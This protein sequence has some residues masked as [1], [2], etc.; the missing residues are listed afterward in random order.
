MKSMINMKNTVTVLVWLALNLAVMGPADLQ[1]EPREFRARISGAEQTAEVSDDDLAAE[2]SFGREV[3]AH[4]L[5]RYKLDQDHDLTRYVNLVGRGVALHCNRSE[6]DFRFAVLDTATINAYAAPGGYIFITRGAIGIMADEAELAAVLA[7][8]VAHTSERHIVRE[9]GIK[10]QEQSA[11]AGIAHLLGAMGD[12]TRVAFKQAVDKAMDIL[13]QQG[14]SRLDEFSADQSGTIILAAT[15][16]D[17]SALGRYLGRLKDNN[18]EALA[19]LDKTHP[20]LDERI[21][22]LD[23]VL[24]EAG[25][26]RI[27]APT[28]QERFNAQTN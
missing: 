10:G 25:L 23:L 16:Y 5:G 4:I 19:I 28:L 27:S 8:E 14:Y 18:S 13:F 22:A 1:A 26:D 20:P 21:A 15:G 12:P 3:A 17:A 2:I 7:H 6:L 9:L 24:T 11:Q